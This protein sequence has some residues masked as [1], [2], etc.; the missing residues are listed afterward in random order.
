MR[1]SIETRVMFSNFKWLPRVWYKFVWYSGALSF[2][3]WGANSLWLFLLPSL[4]FPVCNCERNCNESQ[5]AGLDTSTLAWLRDMFFVLLDRFRPAHEGWYS[6]PDSMP[7]LRST[8]WCLRLLDAG[9]LSSTS[10]P[11]TTTKRTSPAATTAT[12]TAIQ[13]PVTTKFLHPPPRLL[14][15]PTAPFSTSPNSFQ[16]RLTCAH[17]RT[18]L[19]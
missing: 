7:A 6:K 11:S 14:C 4:F 15:F 9:L 16:V 3:V 12:I 10:V 13:T 2:V 19:P 8:A 1:F 5:R 18:K 17:P